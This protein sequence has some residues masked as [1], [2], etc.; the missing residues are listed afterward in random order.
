VS[1]GA[2]STLAQ[3][4]YAQ[5]VAWK[6]V[7]R[8]KLLSERRSNVLRLRTEKFKG[9]KS[10]RRERSRRYANAASL[11]SRAP[12]FQWRSG[13][14]GGRRRCPQ[15]PHGRHGQSG[16]RQVAGSVGGQ[17]F[18]TRHWVAGQGPFFCSRDPTD[19]A[20]PSA[21]RGFHRGLIRSIADVVTNLTSHGS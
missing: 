20:C 3:A 9:R 19:V 17:A 12:K 18:M 21:S 6:A 11:R 4:T 16:T 10:T 8:A 14:K 13:W 7:L 15:A 5:A 2:R 1:V